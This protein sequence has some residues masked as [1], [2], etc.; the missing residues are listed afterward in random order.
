MA[1]IALAMNIHHDSHHA[2]PPTLDDL[3]NEN[4]FAPL[5]L[6]GFTGQPYVYHLAGEG[7]VLYTPGD[8]NK[9]ED[10]KSLE[11]WGVVRVPK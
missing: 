4:I 2:Y 1:L 7:Y 3:K 8:E 5:P 6:D 10:D 11:R 9:V